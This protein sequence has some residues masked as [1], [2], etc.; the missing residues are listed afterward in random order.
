MYRH[1]NPVTIES[2][3]SVHKSMN[4]SLVVVVQLT[5]FLKDSLVVMSDLFF[6]MI[7]TV[8]PFKCKFLRGVH[9]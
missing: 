6:A 9:S 8:Q 2:T 4:S 1:D 5:V 3:R 7:E